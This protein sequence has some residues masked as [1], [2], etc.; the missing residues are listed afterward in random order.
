MLVNYHSAS[1]EWYISKTK[2]FPSFGNNTNI[3]DGW[4]KWPLL[5]LTFNQVVNSKTGDRKDV[6][7]AVTCILR[8][9]EKLHM[10]SIVP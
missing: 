1:K 6:L 9:A 3:S 10:V 4:H 5:H 2:Y 8:F 7:K